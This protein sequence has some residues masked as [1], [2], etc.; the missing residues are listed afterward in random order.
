[1]TKPKIGTIMYRAYVYNQILDN[2]ISF[3]KYK[4]IKLTD[5]G[6]WLEEL[7]DFG[8]ATENIWKNYNT[9]FCSFTKEEAID[10][11]IKRSKSYIKY[12]EHRL[13]LSKHQL[14]V[15]LTRKI[16]ND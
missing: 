12:C 7:F 5:K 11:L 1:M 8:I 10:H 2:I 15:A 14:R 3:S 16:G 6:M 4:V 13:E 9:Y